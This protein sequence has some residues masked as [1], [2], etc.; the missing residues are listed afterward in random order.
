[1]GGGLDFLDFLSNGNVE[2]L[3]AFILLKF[4]QESPKQYVGKE[5]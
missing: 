3:L 4:T 2:L 1:M 5:D